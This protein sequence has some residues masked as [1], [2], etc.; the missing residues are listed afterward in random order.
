MKW[1]MK[2]ILKYNLDPADVYLIGSFIALIPLIVF[3]V[4]VS[5]G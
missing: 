3:V 2:M 5:V 1:I 4:A